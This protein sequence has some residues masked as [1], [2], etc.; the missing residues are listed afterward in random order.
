VQ[1]GNQPPELMTADEY[2]L[3]LPIHNLKRLIP[4]EWQSN[5]YFSGLMQIGGV[6]VITLHLWLDRQ[7][8]YVDN[9]LFNPEGIPVYADM[10][11]TTPEYRK[12]T[13]KGGSDRP[14]MAARKSRFQFVVAPADQAL[15]SASDEAIVDQV[16]NTIKSNF[17]ETA[18]DAQIE[19]YNVVRVPQSV[20]WPKPGLDKFRVSQRSPIDHL[21]LAG[22][23]TFQRFYDSMEGAVRSG[24][25]AAD[26]LLAR[27]R[28][29]DWEPVA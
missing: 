22:G 13:D 28:G 19:K 16:W 6:P 2:V 11:N 8:S 14:A 4:T 23:Y 29:E 1:H 12:E 5:P 25:R 20:Y 26:A 17:P 7:V 10:A 27:Q 21:Y 18:K 9:I 3:A 15:M 24:N